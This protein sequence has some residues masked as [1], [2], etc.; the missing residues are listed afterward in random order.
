MRASS[1]L[2]LV[3]ALLAG[4]SLSGCGD[5]GEKTARPVALGPATPALGGGVLKAFQP[6]LADQGGGAFVITA[7]GEALASSGYDFPP[8]I[9][10]EPFVIDG[11]T[12]RFD[13]VLV[14][15]DD[16][17]LNADPDRGQPSGDY[18]LLGPVVAEARGPW[19]A[20]LAK[21]GGID[22]KGGP[23]ERAFPVAAFTAQTSNGNAD[24]D[25]A[26]RYAFGFRSVPAAAGAFNVNL[27]DAELPHY[28]EMIDNG[29]TILIIGTATFTA[30]AGTCQS[31]GSFDFSTLPTTV[32]FKVGYD[33]TAAYGNCIN[34]DPDVP[35]DTRGIQVKPGQTVIAQATFHTDHPFWNTTDHEAA[36][37]F[38]DQLA[39][40]ATPGAGGAPASLLITD[41]PDSDLVGHGIAPLTARAGGT[42]GWRT[43]DPDVFPLPSSTERTFVN[44]DFPIETTYQ[45]YFR[46]ALATFG[47]L[48]ADGLCVVTQ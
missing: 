40:L 27:T 38:F 19:A 12:V 32:E 37:M 26:S 10:G 4:L 47:H 42:I 39:A 5:D 22:G 23:D 16:I 45:Q 36:V 3:P 33:A 28:Q 18:S 8:A 34:A 31:N 7:S 41:K 21:A 13:H 15:F 30:D 46:R 44:V 48:N 20:D 24:F 17:R 2:L 35:A 25:P 6:P 43:C 9:A 29:W 11:W 14:S 1:K